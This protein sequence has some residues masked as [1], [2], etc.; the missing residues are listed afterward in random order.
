MSTSTP[1]PDSYWV[2]PGRLLA[3]EYPGALEE[4][5]ARVKVRSFLAAGVTHF[6]DL[7][8]E[9]ELE[10]YDWL[11]AEEAVELGTHAWHERWPVRDMSTIPAPMLRNILDRL[12]EILAAGRTAYVHCW[13]GV[14]RTGTVVGCYL[15]RHGQSGAEALET[16]RSLRAGT[17]DG[18][19]DSPETQEQRSRVL[20]WPVG[21]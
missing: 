14:G 10:P 4:A 5:A 13:G 15:V 3:G 16:I 1:I 11:L 19:K 2:V 20:T 18:Y 6:F 21:G 12:D 8:E 7:T 9:R 17:P